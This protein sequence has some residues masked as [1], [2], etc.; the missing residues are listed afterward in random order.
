MA[1]ILLVLPHPTT[2]RYILIT[3]AFAAGVYFGVL[4][5]IDEETRSLARLV[6]KEIKSFNFKPKQEQQS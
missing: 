2:I 1:L 6:L 5:L 4:Y 3:T